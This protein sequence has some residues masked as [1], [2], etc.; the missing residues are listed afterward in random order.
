[1]RHREGRKGEAEQVRREQRG[2]QG[3]CRKDIAIAEG[4]GGNDVLAV[5]VGNLEECTEVGKHVRF[6]QGSAPGFS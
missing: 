6:R 5:H 3:G 4:A 1:M 2:N